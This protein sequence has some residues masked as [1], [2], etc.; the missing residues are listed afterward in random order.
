MNNLTWNEYYMGV[1]ILTSYRSKDPSTK[2]GTCIINSDFKVV[3]IGY[4]GFPTGCSDD[5]LSWE[6]DS[7]NPLDTKY[8]YVVHAEANA[9]LNKNEANLKNCTLFTTLFPCNECA[10][11]CIQSGIKKIVYL[12]DRTD[13]WQFEAARKMFNMVGIG[14]EKFIPKKESITIKFA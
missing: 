8:P 2:V 1:A 10:K 4:N 11:L 3:A 9:I 13:V 5:V 6:K 14:Y 12:N 7:D